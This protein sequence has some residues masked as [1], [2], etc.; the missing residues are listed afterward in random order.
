M[1]RLAVSIIH[2]SAGDGSSQVNLFVRFYFNFWIKIVERIVKRNRSEEKKTHI[3][4]IRCVMSA[5]CAWKCINIFCLHV[6]YA[7]WD[8]FVHLLDFNVHTH[9][10]MGHIYVCTMCTDRISCM[11][12]CNKHLS[13][14]ENIYRSDLKCPLLK[15]SRN[16]QCDLCWTVTFCHFWTF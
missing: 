16:L 15:I 3:I 9:V 5:F 8:S 2:I 10:E 14:L 12:K 7:V 1:S 11:Y 6:C 4:Y 13:T